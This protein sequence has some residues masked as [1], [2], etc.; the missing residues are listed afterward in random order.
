MLLILERRSGKITANW[1]NRKQ[2]QSEI[3]EMQ[4]KRQMFA[5]RGAFWEMTKVSKLF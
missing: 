3:V 1:L 2:M 5:L 4:L